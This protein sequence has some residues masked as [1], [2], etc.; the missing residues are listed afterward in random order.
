MKMLYLF[1]S[2]LYLNFT[3]IL[4]QEG[5]FL[6]SNLPAEI[7][8]APFTG[9]SFINDQ[10]GWVVAHGRGIVKTTNGGE[11][12]S[13][14]TTTAHLN[15]SMIKFLNKDVGY[16]ANNNGNLIKT[17]DGGINWAEISVNDRAY[18]DVIY[19]INQD[20]GFIGTNTEVKKTT[21]GGNT[22]YHSISIDYA[23]SFSFI[24]HN[25]GWVLSGGGK[26]YR[27]SDCGI[28]WR[29]VNSELFSSK[30]FFIDSLLGYTCGYYRYI[31][32]T[33]DG[34][35]SWTKLSLFIKDPAIYR[36]LFFTNANTG[37]VVGE[38]GYIIGTKDG[39]ESFVYST[40][41]T[42]DNLQNVVFV[43]SKTGWIVGENGNI[44]KT[45]SGDIIGDVETISW[46]PDKYFLF[47]NYPNPFNPATTI[48]YAI[49]SLSTVILKVYDILGRE[50]TT[51]VSEE[52]L[53]GRY[54]VTFDGSGLSSGVYFYRLETGGYSDS[55]KFILMK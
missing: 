12:W 34:G 35:I 47:Q 55:K 42:Q 7:N 54:M 3:S 25:T 21:D 32:K 33:T 13:L 15:L 1:V 52:K 44:F 4:A 53:A 26:L 31:A 23:N 49:P 37:W 50:V 39:G 27:T 51:L 43:N 19:F 38:N 30:I 45:V 28:N 18:I 9:V 20:T 14:D 29:E 36:S 40:G 17:T 24:D 41:L 2:I 46:M 6:Q 48:E 8:S 16:A 22:W 10:A 11:E 5:W